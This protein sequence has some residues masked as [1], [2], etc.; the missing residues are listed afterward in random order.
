MIE[1]LSQNGLQVD[2]VAHANAILASG[3]VE[4]AGRLESAM[5]EATTPVEEIFAPATG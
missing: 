4:V 5:L 1:A 2:Y 3:F